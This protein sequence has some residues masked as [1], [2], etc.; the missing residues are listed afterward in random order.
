[1]VLLIVYGATAGV[2]VVQLYA[3]AFF[4]GLM[5][6]GLYVLYV[7]V[8]AKLRPKLMPPL[9][10][11]ERRVPLAAAA[12]R[13]RDRFGDRA[14]PALLRAIKGRSNADVAMSDL[15]RQLFVTLLPAL[16]IAVVI[17]LAWRTATAPTVAVDT[18]GLEQLGGSFDSAPS[19]DAG[20]LAEPEAADG[21]MSEP[22]GEDGELAEPE[23]AGDEAGSDANGEAA[24]AAAEA[25]AADAAQ[26]G[27]P[28]PTWFW[29]HAGI[30]AAFLLA[31]Y[32]LLSFAR[33]EIFRMLLSSFFP[34][35]VL[36]LAVLGAIVFGLATPSEAAAVGS[37]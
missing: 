10:E 14:L 31:Y 18:G 17:G 1:S 23:A 30:G 7:I 37:F 34:L 26:A 2:S 13:V 25:G 21:E 33:L 32:A 11:S 24:A 16:A 22:P 19:G 3:G 36:I 6:A 27:T 20:G 8:L 12:E 15:L 9:P 28:V 29:V 4:P 35:A 5:L